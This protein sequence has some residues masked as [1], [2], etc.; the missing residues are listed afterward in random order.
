MKM[1]AA[2]RGEYLREWCIRSFTE[3]LAG[4]RPDPPHAE[5]PGD[6]RDELRQ[7]I[8]AAVRRP[9]VR[10]LPELDPAPGMECPEDGKAMILNA[11]MR[12]WECNH[13]GFVAKAKA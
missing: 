9:T 2:A 1:A 6:S 12:R 7:A 4:Y 11:K 10:G 13:C 8:A 5:I 3:T